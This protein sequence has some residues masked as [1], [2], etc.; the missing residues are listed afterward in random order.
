VGAR[1]NV[2]IFPPGAD[3]SGGGDILLWHRHWTH[4]N[5]AQDICLLGY[6]ITLSY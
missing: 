3:S 4:Q 6:I 2:V 5:I 1:L